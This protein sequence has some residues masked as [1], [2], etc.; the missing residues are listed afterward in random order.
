MFCSGLRIFDYICYDMRVVVNPKYAELTGFLKTVLDCNYSHGA[1]YR[2]ARNRVYETTVNGHHVVVKIF[3]KPS[4]FNRFVYSVF[5]PTKARRSYEYSSELLKM[6]FEVPEPVGYVESYKTGLINLSC[7][8]CVYSDYRPIADFINYGERS[9]GEL[10]ECR[11]FV[12]EFSSFTAALH[13]R[14]VIHGDFNRDNLLFRIEKMPGGGEKWHFAMID[15]NRASFGNKNERRFAREMGHLGFDITLLS[16]V[17]KCYS[18]IRGLEPRETLAYAVEQSIRY[19]RRKR[20]KRR[21][22]SFIGIRKK[23]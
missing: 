19:S 7:F 23:Q 21:I 6:G 22:L 12:R 13:D 9:V 2:N 18:A 10:S 20:I 4:L 5:R 8:V 14:G 16:A 11:A 15:L 3:G 17:V 1:V